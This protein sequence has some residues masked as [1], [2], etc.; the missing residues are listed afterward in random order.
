MM[1]PN[2]A[3]MPFATTEQFKNSDNDLTM[4]ITKFL[5]KHGVTVKDII[6]VS[7]KKLRKNTSVS[8][9]YHFLAIRLISSSDKIS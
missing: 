1:K 4:Y 3:E 6:R 5:Q 2:T 8:Y 7:F 9:S